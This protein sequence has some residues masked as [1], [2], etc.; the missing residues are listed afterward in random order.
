MWQPVFTS[1]NILTS[2]A[3]ADVFSIHNK[4]AINKLSNRGTKRDK[5]LLGIQPVADLPI[6]AND[7]HTND[8]LG[9]RANVDLV[10]RGHTV[11]G[12]R[13]IVLNSMR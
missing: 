1:T 2:F 3:D 5:I 6:L 13:I 7:K 8:S 4:T 10:D 12:L 11:T 9:C